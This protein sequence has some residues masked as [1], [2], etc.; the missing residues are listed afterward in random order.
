MVNTAGALILAAALSC[1]AVVTFAWRVARFDSAEPERLIGELRLAQWAAVLLAAVSAIPIGL[2]V[3]FPAHPM[4]GAD[5]AVG[6]ILIGW[7]GIV[8][9]RDPREALLFVAV[10]FVAHAFV[11]LAHRPGWFG[12]DLAP[13]WYIAG[14][15]IYD[16]FLAGICYWAR[17]R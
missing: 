6:V 15:V 1:I 7:S 3:A 2:A 8:L 9:Q 10:G 4:A 13:R 16:V 17:R 5:A 14:I 11:S 12:S